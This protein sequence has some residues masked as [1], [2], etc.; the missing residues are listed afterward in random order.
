M[1]CGD[2]TEDMVFWK[3]SG[4]WLQE[5]AINGIKCCRQVESQE[6]RESAIGC[7]NA[8]VTAGLYQSSFPGPM[9]AK[10]RLKWVQRRRVGEQG[11]KQL[12]WKVLVPGKKGML[13]KWSFLFHKW[14]HDRA[15]ILDLKV[16]FQGTCPVLGLSGMAKGIFTLLQ[17]THISYLDAEEKQNFGV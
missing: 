5:R 2:G 16:Q 17:E 10:A 13:G 1:Q 8:L 6:G 15:V 4:Q 9:R 14:I 3:P 7:K 11:H 12:F